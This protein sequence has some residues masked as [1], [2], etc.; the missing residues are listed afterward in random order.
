MAGAVR[1]TPD[2]HAE[3][4]L[5]ASD[6]EHVSE[7]RDAVDTDVSMLEG[8]TFVLDVSTPLPPHGS[9]IALVEHAR[10]RLPAHV[11]LVVQG[12]ARSCAAVRPHLAR[13]LPVS[14]RPA[15]TWRVGTTRLRLTVGNIIEADTDIVVNASNTRLE[16]GSGV[17]GALRRA[18]GPGL[19]AE[20]RSARQLQQVLPGDVIPTG[21][22][23]LHRVRTIFHAATVEGSDAVIDAALR[24]CL[25]LAADRGLRTLTTPALGT[26]VGGLDI[27]RF[28]EILAEAIVEEGGIALEELVVIA[29]TSPQMLA[30]GKGLEARLGTEDPRIVRD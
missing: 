4:D 16:L 26:G 30:L 8:N 15:L 27:T 5:Y 9:A 19:Q 21:A 11:E 22:H 2:A 28:G 14:A 6:F 7:F 10:A 18:A 20:M 23:G 3:A 25:A 17:S 29:W 13:F 12:P 24:R 1:L